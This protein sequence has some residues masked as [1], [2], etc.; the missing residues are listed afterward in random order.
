[1]K[2]YTKFAVNEPELPFFLGVLDP[3]EGASIVLR[4]GTEHP[5]RDWCMWYEVT[6][7]LGWEVGITWEP[8]ELAPEREKNVIPIE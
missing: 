6:L 8:G 4:D 5:R 3:N 2:R 7:K 1:M